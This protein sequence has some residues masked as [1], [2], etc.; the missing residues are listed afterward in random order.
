KTA[1]IK[2]KSINH[3]KIILISIMPVYNYV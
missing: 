2:A 1:G 3:E